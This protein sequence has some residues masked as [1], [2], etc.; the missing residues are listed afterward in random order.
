MNEASHEF[1]QIL[2]EASRHGIP[3]FSGAEIESFSKYFSLV[4]R[5][6]D[7]LHLTTLSG[8]REFA[9]RH[10]FESAFAAQCLLPDVGCVWDLGAGLGVPG[11]PFAILRPDLR[12]TLV[13]AQ[14]NKAIFLKDAVAELRLTQAEILNSRLETIETAGPDACVTARALERMESLLPE[15][16]RI[17]SPGRQILIFGGPNLL[18][19][20][21]PLVSGSW[22]LIPRSLPFS[23][24]RLVID[25]RCFT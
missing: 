12:V 8:P 22:N 4:R 14:K 6:N 9:E 11:I 3:T 17:G 24:K 18:A 5:W 2:G 1:E 20:L 21:R 25:L 15:I 23:E 10:V 19:A 7:R 13:E 16:L